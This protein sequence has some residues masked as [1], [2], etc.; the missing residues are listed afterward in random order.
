MF[1][2]QDITNIKSYIRHAWFPQNKLCPSGRAVC[3]VGVVEG[4]GFSWCDVLQG[5]IKLLL[6]WWGF[7]TGCATPAQFHP[8]LMI[9][10][11]SGTIYIWVQRGV[12]FPSAQYTSMCSVNVQ[13]KMQAENEDN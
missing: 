1:P 10:N 12:T 8:A 6:C 4:E 9:D 11:M 3:E 7:L 2:L 5:Q 13:Q